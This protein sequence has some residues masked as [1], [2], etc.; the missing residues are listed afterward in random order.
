MVSSVSTRGW[1]L[2]VRITKM[3]CVSLRSKFHRFRLVVEYWKC[4]D[5]ASPFE[6]FAGF[7]GFDSWLSTE[8]IVEADIKIPTGMVS[9]VSTRGWVLK[10]QSGD[11]SHFQ[12]SGFIGFDSWLSTESFSGIVYVLIPQHRFIGFDSWLSTE[13]SASGK[14]KKVLA[15]VSSVSTRGWV[16]K[17]TQTRYISI[18]L[19]SFIGFDSW[20]STESCSAGPASSPVWVSS[21]S[22]RGWVLKVSWLILTS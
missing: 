6:L 22:T 17:V 5:V 13:R 11:L 15:E 18:S 14:E 20:L 21:V 7:I 19:R 8:R 2:K 4:K 1:V 3:M 9:S 12:Q 16:L 10:G